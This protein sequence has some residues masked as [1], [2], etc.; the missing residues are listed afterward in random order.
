MRAVY[1]LVIFYWH[2]CS[3][4]ILQLGF[5]VSVRIPLTVLLASW[6]C[7]TV[8]VSYHVHDLYSRACHGMEQC[9]AVPCVVL[10]CHTLCFGTAWCVVALHSVL[11]CCGARCST[12]RHFM[13]LH[14]PVEQWHA[15]DP[16]CRVKEILHFI[17]QGSLPSHMLFIQ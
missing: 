17:H 1:Y 6:P 12:M 4:L 3:K 5:R 7:F 14:G 16:I 8:T 11:L 13:A 9:I 10:W 15:L 2:C